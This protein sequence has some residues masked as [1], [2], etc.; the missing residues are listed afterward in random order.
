M[1]AAQPCGGVEIARGAIGKALDGGNVQLS[2]SRVV[3]L[4]GIDVPMTAGP[5][6]AFAAPGGPAAQ[7]ALS[8]LISNAQII[9]RQAEAKPDRYGRIVAYAETVRGASRRS[10]EADLIAAGFARV[11][12]D[13]RSP[14]CAAALLGVEAA[15]RKAKIGLWAN[16][17][18]D[19]LRADDPAGIVAERGRFAL[20]DGD[21]VSVHESGPTLYLNFG[22]RWSREFAVTIRK[23]NE[24]RFAAAGLDL[25]ALAGRPV[26]VRGWIEAR[27][28]T[29]GRGAS[30][31]APWIEATYPAQIQLAGHD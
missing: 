28:A 15:A 13:I 7:A 30:W 26:Q 2:D 16:P 6:I 19:P 17:Y 18:Y 20:V 10:V 21:V 14:A 31:R 1:P 11:D 22:R 27:A 9:L 23:R 25:N 24:R 8:R 5:A 3:H 29:G 4:A 12:G